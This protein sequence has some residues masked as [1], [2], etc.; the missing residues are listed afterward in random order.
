MYLKCHA[1]CEPVIT[2]HAGLVSMYIT[3]DLRPRV[4]GTSQRIAEITRR[5][6]LRELPKSLEE[7]ASESRRD[8]SKE[9]PQRVAKITGRNSL[10]ESP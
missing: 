3:P 4:S 6:S 8:H 7:T 9:Q 1:I 10:R 5:N 2:V